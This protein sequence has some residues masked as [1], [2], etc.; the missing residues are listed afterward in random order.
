VTPIDEILAAAAAMRARAQATAAPH[1]PYSDPRYQL[2]ETTE[3]WS[4]EAANY[5]GGEMGEHCASWHPAVALA[6]A[7]WLDATCANY[8]TEVDTPDCP[9]CGEGCGGHAEE[10]YHYQ[11]GDAVPCSCIKDALAVARAYNGTTEAVAR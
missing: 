10:T 4:A 9:G 2:V 11:C 7:D 5:L 3:Q 8:R 6:V 1:H